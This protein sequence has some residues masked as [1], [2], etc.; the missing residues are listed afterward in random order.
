MR[1]ALLVM[2][3]RGVRTSVGPEVA[4]TPFAGPDGIP[5]A[6][7]TPGWPNSVLVG[8]ISLIRN[9]DDD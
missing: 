7:H 9:C 5:S 6:V 8:I 1:G 2:S 3:V 4:D